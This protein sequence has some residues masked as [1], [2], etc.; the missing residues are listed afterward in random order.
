LTR[1]FAGDWF[2]HFEI[3]A[4]YSIPGRPLQHRAAR[5][6]TGST[7]SLRKGN[8][9]AVH[10]P[11]NLLVQ[12]FVPDTHLSPCTPMGAISEH[13]HPASR[14]T[15]RQEVYKPVKLETPNTPAPSAP[16]RLSALRPSFG[17]TTWT[18]PRWLVLLPSRLEGPG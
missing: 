1:V 14:F 11:P 8:T 4:S 18:V 6:V 15:W 17:A 3:I 9:V 10:Y 16:T 12:P 7:Y 5:D 2:R 13:A